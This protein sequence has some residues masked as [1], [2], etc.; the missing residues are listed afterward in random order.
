MVDICLQLPPR[1][2]PVMPRTARSA[3][4]SSFGAGFTAEPVDRSAPRIIVN[5]EGQDLRHLGF[6]RMIREAEVSEEIGKIGRARVVLADPGGRLSESSL[7]ME[8]RRMR[9]STGYA[10]TAMRSRGSFVL[11]SPTFDLIGNRAIELVG[12]GEEVRLATTE[13][14][15]A[16]SNLRDSDIAVQIA[17]EHGLA[18]D[19]EATGT[20]YRQVLQAN[21][22]DAALLKG[23][24]RLHGYEF[25]VEDGTLHFHPRRD[26]VTEIALRYGGGKR[27]T[28][29]RLRV[30]VNPCFKALEAVATQVDPMSKEVFE[31]R[32][33]NAEDEVTR[34]SI[35]AA[36]RA[37]VRTRRWDEIAESFGGGEK[38][39]SG[40]GHLQTS[41]EYGALVEGLSQ[42]SRWVVEGRGEVIG[43]EELRVRRTI[44]ILGAGRW[45]GRYRVVRAVHRFQPGYSVEFGIS[46]T[47]TGEPSGAAPFIEQGM[48]ERGGPEDVTGLSSLAATVVMQ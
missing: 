35:R 45:S 21:Q 6:S 33:R 31:A 25:F 22:T 12:Y 24:A 23:R 13:R 18:A 39:V 40:E 7:W 44:T 47:W 11:T 34:E 37:K 5:V 28:L 17:D 42:A 46:R 1:R 3:S 19:V 38:F 27:S 43:L 41:G 30:G 14:R 8:G 16:F 10:S 4:S 29:G 9:V 2:A 20:I 15:R 32:S 26:Q 48:A 36:G